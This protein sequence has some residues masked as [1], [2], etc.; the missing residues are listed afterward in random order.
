MKNEIL[1]CPKCNTY[2]LKESCPVDKEITITPKPAK[3]SIEDRFGEY[4]RLYKKKHF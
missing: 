4:R 1:K 2:T 3:F